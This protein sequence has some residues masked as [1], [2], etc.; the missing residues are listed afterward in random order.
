MVV[1]LE[2]R[3]VLH[4]SL[5]KLHIDATAIYRDHLLDSTETKSEGRAGYYTNFISY[6]ILLLF[7][8]YGL[9]FKHTRA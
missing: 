6:F 4:S 5:L 2:K 7:S 3:I 8:K 9:F 1:F